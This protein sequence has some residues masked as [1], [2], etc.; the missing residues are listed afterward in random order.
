MYASINSLFG[1]PEWIAI[2][3][4]E[5]YFRLLDM[6]SDIGLLISWAILPIF[7]VILVKTLLKRDYVFF[8]KINSIFIFLVL[9]PVLTISVTAGCCMYYTTGSPLGIFRSSASL[10]GDYFGIDYLSFVV[11]YIFWALMVL[12]MYLI[13]RISISKK[14]QD[15]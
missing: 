1:A 11:N 3:N 2:Y 12:V 5:W 4:N 13:S 6:F 14:L 15:N 7:F 8:G 10:P 9:V